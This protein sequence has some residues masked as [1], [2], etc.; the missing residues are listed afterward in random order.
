MRAPDEAVKRGRMGV[1][2]ATLLLASLAASVEAQDAGLMGAARQGDAEAVQTLLA[3]GADP[4]QA[5]GDGMTALHMAAL[6]GHGDVVDVLLAA[7]AEV[8]AT[9]RIGAYTPLH[10]ASQAGHGAVVRS[11]LERGADANL[12]TTNSGATPLH[13]AARVVA[14]EDAVAALLEHGADVNARE[15]SAGQTPLMFAASYSRTPA[16]QVLLKHGADPN[17]ATRVVDVLHSVAIDREASQLLRDRIEGLRFEAEPGTEPELTPAQVQEAI[18]AQREFLR[19]DHA[20]RQFNADDLVQHRA[21]YPGGPPLARPPYRETLVG[22]T[23]GMTALLHAAREGHVEAALA[24]LDGG[25]DIDQVSGDGTSPLLMT[26]INGQFD[27]AMELVE[28]GADPDR[29]ADTDGISPVFAVLQTHWAPKSNYPQPRAQDNE[30]TE[31]LELLQALLDAGADP[32][33]QLNTHLWY[34][35]FGLTK[36]G[37]N[38][39]GATPFYRAAFAQD[40]EAMKMLAAHGADPNIPTRWPAVGMRER[41]Q[42]DGRQQED[43]GLPWIP[44]DSY[45]AYP[46]H[47]AAGG[48]WQ[49]LGAFSVRAV[50]DNFLNAVKYLVDEHGADVNLA[51]SWLYRPIHYAAARGDN[52]LIMYLVEQGADVTAITRLGQSA[53]DMARGGR[54]GFFVRVAYPETEELLVNLGSSR[55]CEHTHFLDT[56]DFC[57]GLGVFDPWKEKG[58]PQTTEAVVPPPPPPGGNRR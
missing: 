50:P 34:W 6:E 21:D 56:G 12:A 57:E 7:G 29:A 28:H 46:I 23:G 17:V 55:E 5:Q 4:S 2:G 9:T 13:L 51:D 42:Q 53:A 32:N 43:S 22:M 54:S 36:M 10:L 24:L 26:I 38:L 35:E 39:E 15:G 45:N 58:I 1:L 18:A 30:Q 49:G 20:Q 27:L 44:E 11:L 41:R 37:I 47:A 3:G 8:G 16:I 48:G 52:E 40:I 19:A 33:V 14:G 25:A 31:Y